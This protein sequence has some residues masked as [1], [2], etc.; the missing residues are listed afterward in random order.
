MSRQFSVTSSK[1]A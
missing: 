1:G